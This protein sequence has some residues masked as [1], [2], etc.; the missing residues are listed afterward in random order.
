[1]TSLLNCA[2]SVR[3]RIFRGMGGSE[4]WHPK[5]TQR[6]TQN[7]WS[8]YDRTMRVIAITGT[9]EARPD[10]VQPMWRLLTTLFFSADICAGC[11]KNRDHHTPNTMLY[12]FTL[13]LLPYKNDKILYTN[14][15]PIVRRILISTSRRYVNKPHS[16]GSSEWA[17]IPSSIPCLILTVWRRRSS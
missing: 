7:Y 13:C 9:R 17:F 15:T 16:W 3:E 2:I 5:E 12:K 1:M 10:N 11:T 4:M 6:T 14:N 8:C